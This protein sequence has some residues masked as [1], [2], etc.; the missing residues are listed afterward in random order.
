MTREP[1]VHG[2]FDYAELERL[3]LSTKDVLDFSVN[4]NPYGPSP[5]AREA[6]ATLAL[7]RYPDRECLALKRALLSYEV[8]STGI[9]LEGLVCGNGASELIWT[10]ARAFLRSG[11]VTARLSPT[12]GEYQAASRAIGALDLAYRLDPMC[13]FEVNLNALLEWLEVERPTLFWLCNPNNPSG[14]WLPLEQVR[15]LAQI[16]EHLGT[17]L[18]IDESYHHFRFPRKAANNSTKPQDD[19]A[20]TLLSEGL[21]VLILRSL[22]KDFALAALRLGYV[23]TTSELATRLSAHL[24]SWNVNGAAQ[25]AATAALSDRAHLERSLNAL[26]VERNAF[27]AALRELDVDVIPSGTHYTLVRVG[28]A[29][30]L[31]T[32]LLRRGLLVRDCSS[33]GLPQYIRVATRQEQEWRRLTEALTILK[34]EEHELWSV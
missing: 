29:P 4:S 5:A 2:A 13:G 18:V 26:E 15:E 1:V 6:L 25:V 22:T 34:R 27:F 30:A 28:N 17:L 21:S 7:E 14:G 10:I 24:P 33:F 8:T 16:C 23:V 12:F 11:M 20:L 9:E 31:R 32:A 19:T 3:G